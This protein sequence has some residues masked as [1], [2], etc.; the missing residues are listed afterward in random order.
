MTR[1]QGFGA[2]VEVGTMV[3]RVAGLPLS[4]RSYEVSEAE[5]LRLFGLSDDVLRGLVRSG[6]P[7]AEVETGRR[8]EFGDLHYI[9]L[10]VGSAT[11]QLHALKLWARSLAIL[12]A[13]EKTDVRLRY[14][15][16]IPPGRGPVPVIVSVP[17]A[18]A[19]TAILKE[20]DLAVDTTVTLQS[21][22]AA[23]GPELVELLQVYEDFEFYILPLRV[24]GDTRLARKSKLVECTTAAALVTEDCRRNGYEARVVHGLFMSL[25]YAS[26]HDWAE[27]RVGNEWLAVDPILVNLL[28]SVGGLA[29]AHWPPWRPVGAA[30]VPLPTVQPVTT[31]GGKEIETTVLT[32]I[33]GSRGR[34]A[35]RH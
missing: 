19:A 23:P 14:L 27:V 20:G 21:V 33:G 32:T 17:F 29:P 22:R 13:S 8:F 24:R 18:T 12:S 34:V 15:P 4:C 31:L 11:A 2:Q 5:A 1:P 7:Y 9:A 10:R 16:R 6:L 28:R 35:R 30:V 3:E 25:P 26:L